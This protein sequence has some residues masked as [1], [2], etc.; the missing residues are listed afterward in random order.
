MAWLYNNTRRSVLLVGLFHS[1]F[2]A[3]LPAANKIIPG[4]GG[5]AALIGSGIIVL[6]AVVITVV[7][8]GRLSYAPKP[9]RAAHRAVAVGRAAGQ[10]PDGTACDA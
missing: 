4:P 8:K 6:A 2:D 3:T 10:R 5:T 9:A 1:A 7:T